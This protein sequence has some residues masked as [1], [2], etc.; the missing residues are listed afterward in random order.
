MNLSPRKLIAEFVK[1]GIVG[2][3]IVTARRTMKL[4]ATAAMFCLTLLAGASMVPSAQ[5]AT[6]EKMTPAECVF[7]FVEDGGLY[8]TTRIKGDDGSVLY[9]PSAFGSAVDVVTATLGAPGAPL[10]EQAQKWDAIRMRQIAIYEK[11][12]DLPRNSDDY[13]RL[14]SEHDDLNPALNAARAELDKA[15]KP[16]AERVLAEC[17]ATLKTMP[18]TVAEKDLDQTKLDAWFDRNSKTSK[19]EIVRIGRELDFSGLEISLTPPT[20]P[21]PM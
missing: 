16:L 9:S 10:A 7:H 18:A 20:S 15:V 4:G 1:P 14:K 2:G 11:F 19:A 12:M 21:K 17:D 3:T 13:R 5:A 6:I 8:D